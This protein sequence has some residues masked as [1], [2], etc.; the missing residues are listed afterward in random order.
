[1]TFETRLGFY[2]LTEDAKAQFVEVLP[3][4]IERPLIAILRGDRDP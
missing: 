1:M 2:R 4:P 3:D